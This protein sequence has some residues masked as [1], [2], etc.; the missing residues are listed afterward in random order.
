MYSV[1]PQ[2]DSPLVAVTLKLGELSTIGGDKK[3]GGQFNRHFREAPKPVPNHVL[4][5]V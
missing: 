5:Y 4:R 3:T 2:A 1:V